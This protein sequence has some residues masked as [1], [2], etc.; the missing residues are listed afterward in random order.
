MDV[1]FDVK[2]RQAGEGE[3]DREGRKGK[4]FTEVAT[5][6]RSFLCTCGLHTSQWPGTGS[7]EGS[8]LKAPLLVTLKRDQ[9]RSSRSGCATEGALRDGC[10]ATDLG[11]CIQPCLLRES[12]TCA[13][14]PQ[15]LNY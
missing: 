4:F 12:D 2:G 8:F 13:F 14:D 9:L 10:V 1:L 6:Q 5:E 11:S 15:D 3:K 7:A